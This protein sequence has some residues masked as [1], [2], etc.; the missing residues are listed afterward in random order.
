MTEEAKPAVTE[1]EVGAPVATPQADASPEPKEAKEPK[2]GS[3]EYNFRELEKAKVDLERRLREQETLNREIV[4]VLKQGQQSSQQ[5]PKEESLPQLSPDDIPEWKHVTSYAEKIAEKK[6]KELTAQYEKQKLPELVK[7][8]YKDFDEVVTNDRVQKLEQENPALAQAIS[9][10]DD[11]YTAAYSYLKAVYVPK[12][13]DPIAMEEAEKI[14]EN[15]TKPVSI[16]AVGQQGALKNANSFQKKSKEQLYKEM[17]SFA[18][19][20]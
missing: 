11:P 1:Q 9:R 17:M 16:N 7:T 3:K 4:G 14:L 18:S 2:P 8:R 20:A 6:F 10:A 13:V 15:S 12:K 19:N 5:Q